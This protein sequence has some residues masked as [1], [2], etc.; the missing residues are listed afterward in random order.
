MADSAIGNLPAADE[1]L[2]GDLFALEQGG[3]AKKLSGS[4]LTEYIDR[5]V[6]SVNVNY[7]SASASGSASYDSST[8]SLTLYIPKGAGVSGLEYVSTDG[9]T[10]LYHLNYE[11]GGFANVY[12]TD[13]SSIQSIAK[14]GTSG[15]TDTYTITLTNGQ[16]STF[17]V[18]NGSGGVDTVAGVQP[19]N[20]GD[21]PAASVAAALLPNLRIKQ[22][23]VS[24]ASVS[25]VLDSSYTDYPYHTDV[26]VLGMTDDCF[27]EI[28]FSVDDAGDFAPVC[29]TMSSAVRIWCNGS[30]RTELSIPTVFAWR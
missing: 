26:P 3:V 2:S 19:D 27:A 24:V 5:N 30:A 21:A 10:K 9:L 4:K 1:I 28:V 23:N 15:L 18:T 16:T 8:G 14:T 12:I 22:T 17:T 6:V 11:A 7:V 20:N 25:W 13:G 29:Q